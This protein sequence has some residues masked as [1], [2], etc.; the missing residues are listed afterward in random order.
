MTYSHPRAWLVLA[1]IMLAGVLIRQIFVLRHRG[2]AKPW[3][4]VAGAALLVLVAVAIAPDFSAARAAPRVS[5]SEVRQVIVARC[6][7]C[8][9]PTP[10]FEGFAQPP[11]G[12]VLDSPDGIAAHAPKI[13]ET[14]ASGYMPLGNLTGITDAERK[15]IAAWFAQGAVTQ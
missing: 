15:K 10:R 8:H 13:A 6:V 11:K 9:S 14:V 3:L 1:A 7:A 4:P 5:F 2:A 12:V